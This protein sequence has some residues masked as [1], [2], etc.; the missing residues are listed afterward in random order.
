MLRPLAAL[1]NRSTRSARRLCQSGRRA[2]GVAVYSVMI[3]GLGMDLVEIGRIRAYR[4]RWGERGLTRLFSAGELD[5]CLG[6]ADAASSLAAR[7][8]AKEA[9]FKA[10]GTG[11]GRGGEWAE[12]RVVRGEGAPRLELTGRAA[13]TAEA[14]GATRY[15][16]TLTHSRAVAGAVVILESS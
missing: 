1:A 10:V 5:Y 9:F 16:L 11:V 2:G 8:A 6:Q 15:H 3:V 4:E 12:V 14:L 13:E 7:F